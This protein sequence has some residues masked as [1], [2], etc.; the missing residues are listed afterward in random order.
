MAGLAA[1]RAHSR[2]GGQPRALK[3]A[4]AATM[5]GV[6][7]VGPQPAGE[8]GS[9]TPRGG[10]EEGG[11]SLLGENAVAGDRPLSPMACPAP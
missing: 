5:V 1:A 4:V 7:G 8:K 9:D 2:L 10:G 6:G 11:N 3:N